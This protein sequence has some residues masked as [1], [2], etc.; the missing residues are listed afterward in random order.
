LVRF[1]PR[2]VIDIR[3]RDP[4]VARSH[5]Y[6]SPLK[7]TQARDFFRATALKPAL[8]DDA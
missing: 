1:S 4:P 5:K 6:T 8:E 7:K 3:E 2:D